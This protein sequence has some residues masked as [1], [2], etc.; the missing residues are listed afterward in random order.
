MEPFT[1]KK[2]ENIEQG[3]V[4][5][6]NRFCTHTNLLLPSIQLR[7]MQLRMITC[8]QYVRWTGHCGIMI[9]WN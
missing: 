6:L 9:L 5:E 7:I 1:K 4:E 8:E 3:Y 2:I